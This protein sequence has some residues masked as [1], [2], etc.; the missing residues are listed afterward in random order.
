MTD[1]TENGKYYIPE[2]EEFYHGFEF[3]E[4]NMMDNEF[5][6]EEFLFELAMTD[7]A[8]HAEDFQRNIKSGRIRVKHLDHDDI[9][10]CCWDHKVTSAGNAFFYYGDNTLNVNYA[11][12]DIIIT[13]YCYGNN[14]S[15]FQGRIQ[16]KSELKRLMK[17][18]GIEI[19]Q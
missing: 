16:N 18:L 3:Q 5:H 6:D 8:F 1:I 4:I 13:C 15:L 14:V 19:N 12:H 11:K 17:Q 7:Y 9:I 2:I 10:S